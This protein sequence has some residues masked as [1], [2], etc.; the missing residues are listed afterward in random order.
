[1]DKEQQSISYL[2]SLWYVVYKAIR[3]WK[4][5][6][7]LPWRYESQ[8]YPKCRYDCFKSR[9]RYAWILKTWK[10]NIAYLSTYLKPSTFRSYK[11]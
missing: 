4:P 2:R 11:Y 10:D 3:I 6:I 7:G 9:L 8:P 1:M 5:R